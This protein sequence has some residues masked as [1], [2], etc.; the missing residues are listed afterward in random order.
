MK[1]T[2]LA[3]G[4]TAALVAPLTAEAFTTPDGVR[5]N[6]VN[7]LIFEVIPQSSGSFS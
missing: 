2:L 6:P 3:L 1:N 5:V 4:L 7:D